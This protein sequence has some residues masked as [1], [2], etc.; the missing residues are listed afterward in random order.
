MA[1]LKEDSSAWK[2]TSIIIRDHRHDKSDG[3]EETPHKSKHGKAKAR[4]RKGCPANNGKQHVYIWVDERWRP[5][6]NGKQRDR[7]DRKNYWPAYFWMTW[8]Q[9]LRYLERYEVKVCC[10]CYHI[11]T[12]RRK[13]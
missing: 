7:A 12:S 11:Y 3:Y 8:E 1:T 2:C 13:V 6:A 9:E 10:G 5:D 4:R